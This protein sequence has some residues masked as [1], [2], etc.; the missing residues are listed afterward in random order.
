MYQNT[1]GFTQL[2]TAQSRLSPSR[3]PI[4]WSCATPTELPPEIVATRW[5][6]C[7]SAKKTIKSNQAEQIKQLGMTTIIVE[8]N[9]IAALHLADRALILDMG[10]VVFDGTAQEVLDNEELRHEYLAI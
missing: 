2:L 8:Q 4:P 7:A 3:S 5:S 6:P 9:A 1:F 10:Q